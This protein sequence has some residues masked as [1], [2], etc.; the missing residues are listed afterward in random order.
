[1]QGHWNPFRFLKLLHM[2]D[3]QSNRYDE[4]IDTFLQ[5]LIGSITAYLEMLLHVHSLYSDRG[6]DTFE[7]RTIW[8][9][10]SMEICCLTHIIRYNYLLYNKIQKVQ[11]CCLKFM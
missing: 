2:A 8:F 6:M 5:H 9:S 1:M 3:Q 10:I 7:M 11:Q 4:L